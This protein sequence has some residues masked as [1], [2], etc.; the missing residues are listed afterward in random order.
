MTDEQTTKFHPKYTNYGIH[1]NEDEAVP[2]ILLEELEDDEVIVKKMKPSA[3]CCDGYIGVS[4]RGK[5][6]Y[7]LHRFIMECIE[8]RELENGEEVDHIDGVKHHN[9]LSNLQILSHQS[10]MK[11]V[12]RQNY[13]CFVTK[14]SEEK[15]EFFNLYDIV[16]YTDIAGPIIYAILSGKILGN[17]AINSN[18]K[19]FRI[20][21]V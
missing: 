18:G 6:F 4:L 5:P 3:R 8:G 21:K 7:Y 12:K 1:I 16:M 15:K 10:N 13:H 19:K 14:N 17:T 20:E 11:K 2:V 9:N